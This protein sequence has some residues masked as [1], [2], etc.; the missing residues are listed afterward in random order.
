MTDRVIDI[1]GNQ[2]VEMNRET[3]GL[4]LIVPDRL[5]LA[6]PTLATSLGDGLPSMQEIRDGVRSLDWSFGEEMFDDTWITNQNGYG[7]C[8]GYGASS[9]LAKA[10]VIGG[11]K[12]V[13][14]SGD[15]QYSLVNDGRDQGSG[16][17]E[18]MRSL[19]K[20]GC[21]TKATVPLG[22]IYPSKYSKAKADAE[23]KRFKAHEP[24][25]TPDEHSVAAALYMRMP[26]VMAIQVTSRWR[27]VDRNNILAPSGSGKGNHCEH[28]DDIK[29]SDEM[30]CF[31][32]RKASSHKIPY[33]WTTWER[34]YK[35]TSR[36]HMFYAVP[37]G[38]QDPE[39]DNPV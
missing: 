17:E 6:Y 19:V 23:A 34:H 32:Y 14:L 13:D 3:F 25:A 7:S 1:D 2:F 8:A 28:L 22:G 39:G 26:V 36:Y 38:I 35:V 21:A 31:L 29:W 5:T 11:Q 30:G 20:N 18:N 4:G 10:R 9:A 15:Y 12:R 33:C 27:E 16:L 24:W 37:S